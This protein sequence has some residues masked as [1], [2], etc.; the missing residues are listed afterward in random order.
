MVTLKHIQSDVRILMLPPF[1]SVGIGQRWRR[2]CRVTSSSWWSYRVL[3]ANGVNL[4][5]QL[6]EDYPQ[7][8]KT[9]CVANDLHSAHTQRYIRVGKTASGAKY[10]TLRLYRKRPDLPC[11]LTSN[12]FINYGLVSSAPIFTDNP[13]TDPLLNILTLER[14]LK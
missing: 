14:H 5:Q 9:G 7:H 13:S 12:V 4:S 1:I 6:T 3:Q 11:I 2:W 10:Y 8:P